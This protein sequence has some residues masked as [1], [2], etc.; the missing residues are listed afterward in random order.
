MAVKNNKQQ[1]RLTNLCHQLKKSQRIVVDEAGA[2]AA[3]LRCVLL[4]TWQ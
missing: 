1:V 2:Q 4:L 3:L